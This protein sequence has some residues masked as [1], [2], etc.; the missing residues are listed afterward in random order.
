MARQE[1]VAVGGF[2][3]VPEHLVLLICKY[4]QP[5]KESWSSMTVVDPCAGEGSAVIDLC[6]HI[7]AKNLWACELEK[8]RHE[9]LRPDY[10][11]GICCEEAP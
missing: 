4:L 1:S 3:A 6:V 11:S 10:R 2:F 7:G 5:A 8:G 9:A